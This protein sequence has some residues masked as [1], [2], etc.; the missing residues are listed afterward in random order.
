[1]AFRVTG[2]VIAAVLLLPAGALAQAKAPGAATQPKEKAEAKAHYDQGTVHFNLD[3][4]PQ[5]IEE[6]RAAYRAYPDAIFLY[7]I[8]QCYRKMGNPAEALSFYRKYLR[9]RPDAP[10]RTEVEKRI[11]ELEAAQAA[12]AKSREAPPSGVTPPAPVVPPAALLP[13]AAWAAPPT[14]PPGQPV[15]PLAIGFAAPPVPARTDFAPPGADVTTSVPAAGATSSSSVLGKW[16][17]WTAIG[18]AVVTGGVV[19]AVIALSST[20]SASHYQGDLDPLHPVV[21]V[22]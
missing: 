18:A 16:W 1:M 15:Q 11:D 21:M 4:W 17:F 2:I 10:N 14:A 20:R 9:E 13:G 3:E 8:A 7:N 5:A 22:P 12:Q 6:F 19:G